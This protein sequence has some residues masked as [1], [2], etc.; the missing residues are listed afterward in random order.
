MPT[1]A[2]LLRFMALSAI[3]GFIFF[4]ASYAV[5]VWRKRRSPAPSGSFIRRWSFS[6]LL[7]GILGMAIT[8]VVRET[9]R[10]DGMVGGDGLYPVR[11]AQ[12]MQVVELADEGPVKQG[13]LLARFS[14][15]DAL[16]EIQQAELNL[17][18]LKID[19]EN[20]NLMPLT[21]PTEL[22]GRFDQAVADRRQHLINLMNLRQSRDT[23]IRDTTH[24]IIAQ[25]DYLA[26]LENEL[27]TAEGDYR[28]AVAK[29]VKAL[30]QL[31]K[32]REL[33]SRQNFT[34][35][36]LKDREKEVASL[37]AEI[38]KH[39]SRQQTIEAQ[40]K[41]CRESIAQVEKHMIDQPTRLTEEE[42]ETRKELLAAKELCE[43]LDKQLV[44][45]KEKAQ[46]RRQF[47]V[48]GLDNKIKQAQVSLQAKQ[49]K[50]EVKAPHNGEVVYRNPS[51]G[52][53]L[54]HGPVL[55]MSPQG[56][57]RFR[58][59][60]NEDQV[61][62]LRSAGTV[63]VELAETENSVEQRFPAKFLTAT[64]SREPG[65]SIVDLECQTPPETVAALAEGKPIKARFSWRPPVM[66][67]W[68]FPVSLLLFGLG[69]FGLFWTKVSGWRPTWPIS[70]PVAPVDEEDI[71][72]T[73]ASMTAATEGDTVEAVADTV[74]LYPELDPNVPKETPIPWEHPVGIRIREAIIR[75]DI[76][77]ELIDAVETAIEQ[78]KGKLIESI[79]E[80][81]GRVPTVPEHARRLVDKLNN[82]DTDDEMKLLEKR[83]LAQRVTFL[84]YTIGLDLP[85]NARSGKYDVTDLFDAA[86]RS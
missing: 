17:E 6:L 52:M 35:I 19:K 37:D 25:R 79:R 41:L 74:P 53:A 50:V 7:L 75:E 80:A 10:A 62:A 20:L 46:Q 73:F 11:A 40:Q 67:L 21:M 16:A 81:L 54:N 59:R 56:G 68:P 77:V 70:K 22:V 71:T 18:Q 64:S 47:E 26:R 55:V 30:E 85:S 45:E 2:P 27:R 61:E 82:A 28:Q 29:R 76:S 32:E 4:C 38:A 44:A 42:A 9:V 57:M 36:D 69:V 33:H 31:A 34:T 5:L 14:S 8:V 43:L 63:M 3:I 51:P 83:C 58:F 39:Q 48:K 84:L 49:D 24:H 1:D 78:K 66:N 12:G 60:L 72:V 13:D 65:M 23:A 15:P 86:T